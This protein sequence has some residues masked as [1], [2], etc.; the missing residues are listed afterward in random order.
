[1]SKNKKKRNKVYTGVDAAITKPVITRIA[2]VQRSKIGQF[3][4]ERKKI[5]KPVLIT[6]G[7]VLFVIIL[8][9]QIVGLVNGS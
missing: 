4:F 1:M 9:F 3:W 6:S 2:A 8:I 5:L 7:I